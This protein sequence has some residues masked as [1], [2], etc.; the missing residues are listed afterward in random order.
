MKQ[1]PKTVVLLT[2]LLALGAAAAAAAET[3]ELLSPGPGDLA[4]VAL[5]ASPGAKAVE[6]SRDPVAVSWALDADKALDAAAPFTA[7]SKEYWVEVTAGDLARGVAVLTSAP[8][9]LVR[10]NPAA[11]EKASAA[12]DPHAFVLTDPAGKAFAAGTGMELIATAEE[13]R[14]AGAPFVEGTAAFRVRADLGAGTFDLKAPGLDA[15]RYVMHVLDA[16]SDVALTLRTLASD[17]LHGQR[18]L[19]ETALG[20]GKLAMEIN[21][22]VTSPAGRA[23]PVTF[24]AAGKGVYRGALE[25]DALEAPAP[26]LWEVHVA[27]SGRAAAGPVM[28][29][30]RSAFNVAV[31]SARFDGSA[32][33]HPGGGLGVRLGIETASEGRYEVRGALFGTADDGALRPIAV[34][35]GAAYLGAGHGVL[36]LSFDRSLIAASGLAAPFEIRD[37]RLVDQGAM[38]LL[39]RQARGLLISE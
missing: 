14:A 39:H 17:Y 24:S 2:V 9:A 1:H 13:L 10:L 33:L 21:G 8:G 27:G 11:G 22:F 32:A 19:V 4:A 31:P 3:V 38:G 26:G 16:G 36:E 18:L 5:V 23:W 20:G 34:A 7:E 35:H 28:R 25:L 29:S 15:G 30:A 12:L 6:L 37:L